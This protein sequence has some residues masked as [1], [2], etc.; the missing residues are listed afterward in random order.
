[1]A[2]L[3]VPGGTNFTGRCRF[4]SGFNLEQENLHQAHYFVS[5][6]PCDLAFVGL[7]IKKQNE[8][9]GG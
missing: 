3:S 1:M 7:G 6:K 9:L 8:E 2:T 5:G 4:C